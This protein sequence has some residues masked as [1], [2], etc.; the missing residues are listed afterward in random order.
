MT[1]TLDLTPT[2]AGLVPAFLL[3]LDKG[4]REGRAAIESELA[5]MAALADLWASHVK[6]N[7]SPVKDAAQGARLCLAVYTPDALKT[8]KGKALQDAARDLRAELESALA[9]LENLSKKGV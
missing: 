4:N 3:V 6:A 7:A 1:R 5:R 9:T 2:W 8:A